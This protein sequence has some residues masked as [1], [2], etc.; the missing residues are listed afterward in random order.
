MEAGAAGS[1][2]WLHA[3]PHD[4]KISTAVTLSRRGARALFP[5][6][7]PAPGM[8]CDDHQLLRPGSRSCCSF[9]R[10]GVG[11]GRVR[12]S[13]DVNSKYFLRTPLSGWIFAA[14][15]PKTV[16][17]RKGNPIISY[18]SHPQSQ[19]PD[20]FRLWSGKSLGSVILGSNPALL[21]KLTNKMGM[22]LP[23]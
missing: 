12:K 4:L 18:P 20:F 19:I 11:R 7:C 22:K 1:L 14:V 8:R 5:S 16:G 13:G 2:A 6:L 23:S 10:L 15:F 9:G 21:C 3:G 17:P